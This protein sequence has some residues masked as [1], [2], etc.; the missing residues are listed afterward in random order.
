MGVI[1]LLIIAC[2][3]FAGGFLLAFLWAVKTGQF[4]D[5]YTPSMRILLDDQPSNEQKKS[6]S[7]KLNI[8]QYTSSHFTS[9]S[10]FLTQKR[11]NV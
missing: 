11:R 5:R 3:V 9:D 1:I 4:D 7:G 10:R 2:V 6:N 8:H